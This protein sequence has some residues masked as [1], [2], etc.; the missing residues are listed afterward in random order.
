MTS[1]STNQEGHEVKKRKF[2]VPHIYLLLFAIAAI[3]ALASWIMPAGTFDRAANS[4]GKMLV[5]PGTYHKVASTPVTLFQLFGSIYKG[6]VDAGDII[7]FIFIS[8]SS[9]NL[10]ISSGVLNG[11][12][13]KLLKRIRGKYRTIIIPIFLLIIGITSSTIGIFEEMYPFIPIFAGITIAMGY[14]AIVGTA[15][16]ALATSIGF[17]CAVMNPFNVGMAQSIAGV[18]QLS[19][20]GFRIFSHVVM[21]A[22]ASVYIIRYAL[23]VEVDP[24]KSAVYGVSFDH[25]GVDKDAV[26]NQSFGLREKLVLLT[27]AS[28]IVVI[29]WGCSA[30]GWYFQEICTVFFIMGIVSSIIMGWS[31][32]TICKK[33]EKSISEIAMA[34]LVVGVA[35]SILIVLNE[36]NIMDTIIY[37]LSI[38]LLHLPKWI[39]GEAMLLF[40][41]VLNFLIPSS[42]G[43]AVVSMPIMAPLADILHISRQVAVLAFQYGDGL[44]NVLWPTASTPIICAVAGIPM[45]KWIKWFIPLFLLLLLTEG[46]LIAISIAIGYV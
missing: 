8:Y 26:M 11:L 23:Q 43:M 4:A 45:Q 46:I 16:V 27:L 36:G 34:A 13:S 39:A 41:T 5:V 22:V 25:L 44:S 37:A 3:C 35:R 2:E 33:I 7:F 29:I 18:A 19:G 1:P 10:I 14:D 30:K 9:I 31:A 24:S 28:G 6:L 12:V 17:S 15:I 40:Q 21:I 38:P 32:N 42:S 20:S